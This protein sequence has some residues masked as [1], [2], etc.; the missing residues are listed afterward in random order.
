MTKAPLDGPEAKIRFPAAIGLGAN[1]GDK[2]GQIRSALTAIAGLP[3]TVVKAVSRFYRTE[4]VGLIEQ[5]WFVNAVAV[6]ETAMPPRP[7]LE[8]LLNIETDLGRIRDRKWG[9][10]LIDLDLLYYDRL[11]LEEAGL[12]LPHPWL[13][14][15][16][17]VLIPL[18]D[19]APDWIHPVLG[20]NTLEMLA[21]L[22]GTSPEVEPLWA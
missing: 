1:L 3:A 10:R 6:V 20:L 8:G 14:R 19:I 13:A 7:L 21:R 22:E 18:S 17:F 16:R 9:P 11:V 2:T 15:R 5:D 12:D 4:P